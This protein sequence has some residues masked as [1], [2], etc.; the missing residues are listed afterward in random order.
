LERPTGSRVRPR[1]STG[2]GWL[3]CRH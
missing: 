3:L 2:D 1:P